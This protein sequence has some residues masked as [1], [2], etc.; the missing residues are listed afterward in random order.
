MGKFEDLSGQKFG[1]LTVKERVKNSSSGSVRWKCLCE[2]GNY[3]VCLA[4]NL[5][6]GHTRSC[7]CLH[8][9]G[10]RTTHGMRHTRLYGIWTDM[11]SRC[12]NPN[13]K[14]YF[15]YG[16]RGITICD[17]WHNSFESFRDWAMANGYRDDLSIDRV[18][19]NG[20][21]EPSNCRWIPREAQAS[22]K[23][24]NFLLTMDGETKTISQ[25]ERITGIERRTIAKRKKLGWTD[26]KALR[27]PVKNKKER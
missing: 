3:V 14:R 25:W 19:V 1:L 17:E 5:K 8:K 11:K 2:C 26:E 20:N 27:Q 23:R 21:Y 13:M 24:N 4:Y 16:G 9:K 22:N 18:D 6:D 7:G 15:D 12:D 10:T